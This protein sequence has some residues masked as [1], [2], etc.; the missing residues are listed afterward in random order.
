MPHQHRPTYLEIQI[1]VAR[2][3]LR[4][5]HACYDGGKFPEAI[6]HYRKV[7]ENLKSIPVGLVIL[8]ENQ[9][10]LFQ[11]LRVAWVWMGAAYRELGMESTAQ[12][13][14][15][16][17]QYY[18]KVCAKTSGKRQRIMQEQNIAVKHILLF[19]FMV[20]GILGLCYF[21]LPSLNNYN[22]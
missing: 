14:F 16:K 5:G 11:L 19:S 15:K 20:Y 6:N 17:E 3:L 10:K 18:N 4:E 2:N 1:M 21:T 7:A 9:E 22:S 13:C 12:E 8:G